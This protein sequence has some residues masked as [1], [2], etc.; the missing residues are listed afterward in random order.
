MTKG[1]YFLLVTAYAPIEA[2]HYRG[3][4]SWTPGLYRKDGIRLLRLLDPLQVV[5]SASLPYEIAER[6]EITASVLV[7]LLGFCLQRVG[8]KGIANFLQHR[9][10]LSGCFVFRHRALQLV[11]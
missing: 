6:L 10:E 11:K 3:P 8:Q 1:V 2:R 4:R 7:N 5:N 9:I